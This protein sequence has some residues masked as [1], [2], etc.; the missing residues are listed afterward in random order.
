MQNILKLYYGIDVSI[1]EPGYFMFQ[2]KLYYIY[3][4]EDINR[5]LEIYRYYRYLMRNCGL[6]GFHIVKNCHQ[7]LVSQ[8]C[9]VLIYQQSTFSFSSYLKIF[10]Q[11]LPLPLMKVAHI[12]E[13][14]IQK[15][16]C[17][18][19]K[20]KDYAYSFKHDQ[21]IISLIYYY[22]G[23]GENSICILNEILNINHQAALPLVLSLKYPISNHVYELLNPVHY[24]ISTRS[25]QI[26]CLLD[27][28]LLSVNDVQELVESYYFD[29]YEILY[30]YA[31][32]FYPAFFLNDILSGHC[33]QEHIQH[34]Y[35]K[36]HEER[37][38]Y[39]EMMRIL[40]FYVRL[41]KISWI[42]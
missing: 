39:K 14:W 20:V 34:Y 1:S 26:V 10:L 24:T 25:R 38:R 12:K 9:I 29:V 42:N 37:E 19:E 16:D 7:D 8:N 33:D 40:S 11:P 35:L 27:S 30:L 22:S 18:K 3:V 17:V 32:I 41:P 36:L 2:Q 4:C 28:H 5:F 15:I 31:R 21:D 13:K 6:E 23:V